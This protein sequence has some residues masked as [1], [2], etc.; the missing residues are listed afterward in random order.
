M[1]TLLYARGGHDTRRELLE[2]MGR[3]EARRRL[4][5]VPEQYSHESERD[6]CRVLGNGASR[7]CE[8][9]SFTR[10]AGRVADAAGGGA[11]PM[12]DAG[13]RMLLMYAALRQVADS[14]SVYRSPSRKPA[15]LTGLLSTVDECKSYCV[16]PDALIRAGEE[17]GGQQGNKLRDIGLIYG[18]YEEL[19]A[20][21]A[22]DPRSRLDRLAEQLAATRWGAGLDVFVHGFTDFT[23]QEERVLAALAAQGSLTVALVRDRDSDPSDLFRSAERAARRLLRMAKDDHIPAREEVLDR[24]RDC[25]PSLRFMEAHLFGLLPEPWLGEC[26]VTRVSAADRRL[27]VEWTAAEILRLL[28]EEN[29]RCRDIAVCARKWDGY[30]ELV[31]SVFRQYGIPVFQ[32]VVEDV[33]QKPVLALV[34]SALAAAAEDYPYEELFRYLKTDLTGISRE[35]RDLLENYVL[36]WNIRGGTWMRAKPWDMHPEGYGLPFSDEQRA[37]V[38]RL[39]GLRRRVIAPLEE[40]RRAADK[41]GRGRALA[42]YAMLERIDLPRRL[43]QRAAALEERG[44]LN[45]AA[46]YR[47]LW[48]ILVGG[49]EQCALLLADTELELDEF[50]RLFSL[51]LSQYDVGTIPVSL[52]RVAVGEAP[53]MAHKE[54][55]ILFFLGTDSG[56]IP[57]NVEDA[58]LFDQQDREA[59]AELEVELAP[60]QEDKLRREFTIAYETCVLPTQRLYLTY[61]ARD[62]GGQEKTPCFLWERLESLFPQNETVSADSRL[63]RLAA[64]RPALELAGHEEKLA[65]VLKEH[66]AL[67]PRM[68]RLEQAGQWRRGS[69]SPGAVRTLF[70]SAVPMSATR[71]DLYNSCHFSHFLRFGLDAKPRQKAKFRPSDYGTFIHAVLE[72]VLGWAR[73]NGSIDRLARSE[74]LRHSL[75][76]AA[77][78]RYEAEELAGLEGETARFRRVFQRMKQSALAV[79]DSVVAELAASEFAPVRFELG[80]GRGKELPPVEVRNGIT[81][82]LSGFVDR[83]DQ[84]LH[85]GKRYLRVVDYKTGKKSFDFSDVEDG[86]GLQMLLYLFALTRHGELFGPEEVVPAGVLY[87]PARNPIIRGDRAM[88]DE[89]IRAAQDRELRRQGLVLDDPA[90]MAAMEQGDGKFRFLPDRAD[91]HV[92]EGQMAAL[93]E[94]VTDALKK[95]AGQMAAGNIDADPY[96]HDGQHNACRWCDYRAACHFEECCGDRAR[97]RKGISGKEFWSW[98]EQRKEGEEHGH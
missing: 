64:P 14:L 86:R 24:P 75:T 17:L 83:V 51:V 57:G 45:S 91:Y 77:A 11:A 19:T 29:Y 67:A 10:L 39:D 30:G 48:D 8:V 73:D 42:L 41:T 60:R 82:R 15:F 2:R 13:G 84:W 32:S 43:E 90:V 87:V 3:S 85:E 61:A 34:T 22:A 7:D 97:Y 92:S 59:L 21:A 9:L 20:H 66:E 38:E 95:A 33:L 88:T 52:D 96:W 36:T 27:E 53:R 26:A 93:D 94:Y 70:G 62:G 74:E 1:L 35:E 16:Q 47:Q 56:A 23:P 25:H 50:S 5:I 65:A 89:D 28:R 58:T 37:L 81:L 80:F 78:D 44:D 40:L 63:C 79:T 49:L 31:D 6:M 12:L 4:L 71:L 72:E 98:M 18:A 76:R 68:E 69:L 54:A 55:K 46:Q